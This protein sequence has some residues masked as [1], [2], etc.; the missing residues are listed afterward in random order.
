MVD[1][2]Y[3]TFLRKGAKLKRSDKAKLSQMNTRL[4][5]LFTD[6]SQNVLADEKGYVTWIKDKSE[7]GGLPE[8]VIAAMA[9]AAKDRGNQGGDWAIT[10]TRSSMDPFLTYSSNNENWLPGHRG[11]HPSCEPRMRGNL[12]IP[13]VHTL[14]R[15]HADG[16]LS[17]DL[18]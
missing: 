10:N 8:S 1:D 16:T 9:N 18:V 17:W 4:A 14:W 6:F 5:R 3:K 13:N 7:L 11:T 12:Q 2:T 15:L